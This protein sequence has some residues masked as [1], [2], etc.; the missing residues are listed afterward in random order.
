MSGKYLTVLVV[1]HDE[2]NVRRLRVSYRWLKIGTGVLAALLVLAVAAVASYG[3]VASR[4][5]R[6][7]LLER[8]N[9]RL[10]AENAKVEEIAA[11][12]ERSE[13]AYEQIRQMAGLPPVERGRPVNAREEPGPTRGV[14][15][16]AE[17]AP[18]PA[19]VAPD[20]VPSGWPLALKGFESAG[21]SGTDEH[22]GV[23][24][25]V[26]VHT[27]VLATAA[28]RV[29]EAESDP[30][31][32]HYVLLDHGGGVQTM[33]GHNAVLLVQAGERVARGQTIAYSGNSG[34]S[35]APHLHYEVR[36]EGRAVDPAP[37]LR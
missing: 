31:F 22:A 24:I 2:R 4:A 20:S 1:P 8:E 9:E 14:E 11:N 13:R 34:R 3:W 29:V 6:A 17:A 16:A 37:F 12:L 23:D 35:T 25:A 15:E 7:A 5:T 36:R 21:F 32:G 27:P 10:A 33:Y 19:R 26:P 30:V 28:G 18:R